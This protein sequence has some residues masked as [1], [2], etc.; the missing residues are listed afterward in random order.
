MIQDPVAFLWCFI[1]ISMI[2][3]ILPS[4]SFCFWLL[5]SLFPWPH[6]CFYSLSLWKPL[7]ISSGMLLINV[8]PGADPERHWGV[9]T[10]SA[11]ALSPLA[12]AQSRQ[13]KWVTHGQ[14]TSPT[15]RTS[16]FECEA[17]GDG[18]KPC[19]EVRALEMQFPPRIWGWLGT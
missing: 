9:W 4:V 17:A 2:S 8:A 11:C 12:V 16:L 6:H 3:F 10:Q 7:W 13:V 14:T 5:L 18:A 15:W 1:I 19:R